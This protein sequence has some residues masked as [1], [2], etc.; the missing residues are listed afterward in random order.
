M[1]QITFYSL[2]RW[3]LLAH[4]IVNLVV[5]MKQNTQTCMQD[6]SWPF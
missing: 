4:V 6:Q 2:I 5:E 3:L 1:A